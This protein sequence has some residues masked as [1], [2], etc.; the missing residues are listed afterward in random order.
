MKSLLVK[1]FEL[2]CPLLECSN[3][4]SI[5]LSARKCGTFLNRDTGKRI[6]V[7]EIQIYVPAINKF[8]EAK[9]Q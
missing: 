9:I 2:E 7:P 1:A 3:D 6:Y 4:A 5:N 8:L